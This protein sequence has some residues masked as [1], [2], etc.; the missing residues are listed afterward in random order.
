M[1]SLH[2]TIKNGLVILDV[3]A[4]LVEGTRVEVVPIEQPQPTLGMREA[5][6]PTTPAAIATLL[7]R[8]DEME[9]GWLSEEDD[10]EWRAALHEEKEAEKAQ[11]GRDVE[12]L[13]RMWE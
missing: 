1:N 9:P 7:A 2:G 6:W 11:F 12:K 13:G 10:A 4:A 8:M 5:D 3:P